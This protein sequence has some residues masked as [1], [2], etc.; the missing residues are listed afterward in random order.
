MAFIANLEQVYDLQL[1][2]IISLVDF[3]ITV[4]STS[5]DL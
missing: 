5:N 1:L 4:F 2:S 3:S